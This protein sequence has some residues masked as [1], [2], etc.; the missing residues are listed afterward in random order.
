MSAGGYPDVLYEALRW[1]LEHQD[2]PWGSPS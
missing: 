2:L 1:M